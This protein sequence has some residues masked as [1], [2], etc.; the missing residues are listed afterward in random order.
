M[1]DPD[2]RGGSVEES[3]LLSETGLNS[4]LEE[5]CLI[6]EK[7]HRTARNLGEDEKAKLYQEAWELSRKRLASF[8]GEEG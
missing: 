1:A 5:L 6:F 7:R 3:F 4:P 8:L 2:F